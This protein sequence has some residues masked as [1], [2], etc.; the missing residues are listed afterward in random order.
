[1]RRGTAFAIG[2]GTGVPIGV[3]IVMVSV[4]YAIWRGGPWR[5]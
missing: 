2:L 1:M 4:G 5:L 3:A